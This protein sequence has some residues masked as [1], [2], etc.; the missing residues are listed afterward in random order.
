MCYRILRNDLHL[1]CISMKSAPWL[2]TDKQKQY[3][4]GC[5]TPPSLLVWFVPLQFILFL[6]L[7]SQ[8]WGCHFQNDP[9]I[10]GQS[11]T[12]LHVIPG[13]S[14]NGRNTKL[15]AWKQK[16]ITMTTSK[17]K[18]H[19]LWKLLDMPSYL[20]TREHFLKYVMQCLQRLWNVTFA[21]SHYPKSLKT[22]HA[23]PAIWILLVKTFF[24]QFVDA[25]KS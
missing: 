21:N 3:K 12:I 11:L 4:H 16:G 18:H 10:Q 7:K 5:G 20:K 22:H 1:W 14:S 13:T 25:R 23:S 19:Q 8:P 24:V 15:I 2:L 17:G 6:W 9:D